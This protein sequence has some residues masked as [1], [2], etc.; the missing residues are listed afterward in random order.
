VALAAASAT[1]GEGTVLAVEGVTD[2]G[3]GTVVAVDGVA[4]TCAVEVT[5][6]EME[7]G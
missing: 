5:E 6:P 2:A 3:A 1:S 7:A 4:D